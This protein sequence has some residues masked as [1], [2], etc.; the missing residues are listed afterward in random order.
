MVFYSTSCYTKT[1]SF[2]L[3]TLLLKE[4]I[5][6]SQK[7][8]NNFLILPVI[9][10]LT[11]M[12]GFSCNAKKSQKIKR[13]GIL[14]STEKFKD[15]ADGFFHKMKE[16]GYVED[17]NISYDFQITDKDQNGQMAEK[18][19]KKFVEDKVDI[20]F[21]ITHISTTIAKRITKN[22]G[23]PVVFA[24]A[25]AEEG[26]L[27]EKITKP[28]N[29]ITGV[30]FPIPDMAIKRFEFLLK[31]LPETKIVW[32]MYLDKYPPSIGVLNGLCP[33]AEKKGV[34]IVK[35]PGVNL[36]EIKAK[37]KKLSINGINA[38]AIHI[39]PEPIF[40]SREGW[41]FIKTFSI[42]HNIPIVCITPD[43]VK[44]DGLFCY[45]VNNYKM[46]EKAVPIVNKVLNGQ[47][48]GTI[49]VVSPELFLTINYKRAKELG[50]TIPDGM[51]KIATEIYK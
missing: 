15:V 24:V 9:F 28:G 35:I 27:I 25:M 31:I 44:D 21:T 29:N 12:C 49:P 36:D 32:A 14:I 18:I 33:Y 47:S 11:I 37:V 5:M 50:L 46:G 1:R 17:K 19:C 7:N 45:T 16:L 26:K 10:F 38:D 42:K 6:L 30:R 22:T 8:L 43:M 51:L 4:V 34:K 48:A 2:I 3:I 23:I 39:L 40:H 41:D 20:I 13:I